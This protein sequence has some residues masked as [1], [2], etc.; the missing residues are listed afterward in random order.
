VAA[1]N[2]GMNCGDRCGASGSIT[3]LT[4]MFMLRPATTR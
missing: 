3:Q 4:T 2:S 1:A